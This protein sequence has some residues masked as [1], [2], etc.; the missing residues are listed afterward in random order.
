MAARSTFS[1]AMAAAVVRSRIARVLIVGHASTFQPRVSITWRAGGFA[2]PSAPGGLARTRTVIAGL[3]NLY[4]ILLDDKPWWERSKNTG[5][6]FA[7]PL[8]FRLTHQK[9]QCRDWI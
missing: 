7:C 5:H 9:K 3:G 6:G 2:C 4:L 1:S 8:L